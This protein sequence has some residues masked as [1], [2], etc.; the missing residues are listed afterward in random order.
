MIV[1]YWNDQR[2]AFRYSYSSTL[3]LGCND[4]GDNRRVHAWSHK[5]KSYELCE[6][7]QHEVRSLSALIERAAGENTVYVFS[8]AYL[9]RD[10]AFAEIVAEGS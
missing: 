1:R 10:K 3:P 7:T 8:Q 6:L 5:G 2:D 4:A 9:Q